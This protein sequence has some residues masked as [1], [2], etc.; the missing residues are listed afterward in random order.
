MSVLVAS[1]P[2]NTSYPIKI[3]DHLRNKYFFNKCRTL[4]LLICCVFVCHVAGIVLCIMIICA[5]C[6]LQFMF[7]FLA[8]SHWYFVFTCMCV[9]Q[10]KYLEYLESLVFE[11]YQTSIKKNLLFKID[12]K[13]KDNANHSLYP[14]EL[15]C[16]NF[17][18]LNSWVA[19][20]PHRV[21]ET[22]FHL[23]TDSSSFA[24]LK[25]RCINVSKPAIKKSDSQV[26]IN[27]VMLLIAKMTWPR[28][29]KCR[30]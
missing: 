20:V 15:Q 21:L 1:L 8:C 23:H 13:Q 18:N 6:F 14:V 29:E 9:F 22:E 11:I 25:K 24:D 2:E 4:L 16:H 3:T 19:I 30:S 12:Q 27:I 17:L 10:D 26:T 28:T 7:G 5:I